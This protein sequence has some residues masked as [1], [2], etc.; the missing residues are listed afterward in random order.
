MICLSPRTLAGTDFDLVHAPKLRA[1]EG[2]PSR[3]TVR[4]LW[5]A[6]GQAIGKR[7]ETVSPYPLANWCRRIAFSQAVGVQSWPRKAVRFPR[8]GKA[9]LTDA[10][11][12]T[13]E[14]S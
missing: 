7:L 5:Q 14:T 2:S 13:T 8:L 12:S 9:M 11:A 4:P 10:R 1:P 6:Q 3:C